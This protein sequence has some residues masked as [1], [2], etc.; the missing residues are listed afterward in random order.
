M[1]DEKSL[2]LAVYFIKF[3]FKLTNNKHI[4]N[5][6]YVIT[7]KIIHKNLVIQ[8]DEDNQKNYITYVTELY[9][10]PLIINKK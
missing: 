2:L 1:R 6:K 3:I 8:S 5:S 9:V 10:H 4:Q 7:E